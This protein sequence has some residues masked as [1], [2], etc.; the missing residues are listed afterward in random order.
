[1]A[2]IEPEFG[3][4]AFAYEALKHDFD[5]IIYEIFVWSTGCA[6][7]FYRYLK[8]III[9]NQYKQRIS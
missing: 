5:S 1:M 7:S 3:G 9:E 4:E 6:N 2:G 8:L